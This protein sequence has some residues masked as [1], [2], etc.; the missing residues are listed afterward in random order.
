MILDGLSKEE[1]LKLELAT[2]VPILYDYE[3]EIFTK[4]L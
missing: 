1:V 3:D 2:G 4:I